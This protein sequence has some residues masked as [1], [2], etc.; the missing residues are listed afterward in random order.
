MII[1]DVYCI[2][3]MYF[4]D[5]E[6]YC[7]GMSGGVVWFEDV[8]FFDGLEFFEYLSSQ[9]MFVF[10][11]GL[12][13][14]VIQVVGGYFEGSQLCDWWGVCFKMMWRFGVG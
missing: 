14:D 9:F 13:F 1:Y 8:Y 5:G 4:F 12:Y 7:F 6:G 3:W 2:M 10:G 11:D